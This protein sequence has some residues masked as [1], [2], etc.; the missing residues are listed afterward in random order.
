[1]SNLVRTFIAVEIPFDV[2]DRANKMMARLRQTEAKVKW[3]AA[4]HMHWT[5]K[6]LGPVD[7]TDIPAVCEAVKRAVE[8]LACFDVDA[9]GAGAFP[10]AQRP[11]TLWFGMGRGT[12]QMIELHDAIEYELAK[13]GFRSENRRY[14][15]HVTIGRVRQSPRGIGELGRLLQ[16][17]ENFD[18]GVALV[19]EVVVFSS[20]LRADGPV[21]EPLCHVELK[22]H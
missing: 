19:D 3:V 14:R 11:R 2:K 22:G 4:E 8:P 10:D 9:Q 12:E 17:E 21:Y 15:P 20:E 1:M 6:F 5:L 16:A 7:M 18:G 13:L